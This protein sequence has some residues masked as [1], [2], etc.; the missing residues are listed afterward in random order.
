MPT[1]RHAIFLALLIA[2]FIL[3]ASKATANSPYLNDEADYCYAAKLGI[4]ANFLDS[5]TM[6]VAEFVRI[7]LSRGKDPQQASQLSALIRESDDVLLY[8][9]WHGPLYF[10]WLALTARLQLDE[11]QMRLCALIFPVGTLV[12]IYLG[13]LWIFA[14]RPGNLAAICGAV[15]FAWTATTVRSTELAPHQAFAMCFVACLIFL[16]KMIATGERRY[17]YGAIVCATLSCCLLE[18]GNVALLTIVVC[19][20]LQ[21]KQLAADWPFVFRSLATFF[22]TLLVVWPGAIFKLSFVKGYLGLAYLAAFRK[23]PWGGETFVEV[24]QKRWSTAP[25]EWLVIVAAVLLWLFVR[26]PQPGRRMLYPFAIAGAL[27]LIATLRVNTSTPRYALVFQPVLAVLAGYL[28]AEYLATLKRPSVAYALAGILGVGLFAEIYL[29]LRHHPVNPNT[30]LTSL[31]AFV[32]DNHLDA[33]SMYV[34]QPDVPTLHYYF[35]MSHLLGYTAAAPENS[36]LQN[37]PMQGVLYPGPP[38]R[39]EFSREKIN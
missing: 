6:P 33:A 10:Y 34:P 37:M 16:S 9:H 22:A 4:A 39:F 31:L 25:V 7:G 13:A 2:G 27:M 12:I 36:S 14:G 30:R 24:W 11:R 17:F 5:P 32:R 38:I 23:S 35:P 28:L 1:L 20:F 19:G 26:R 3:L 29:N 18:V 15:L 21:R 8:R